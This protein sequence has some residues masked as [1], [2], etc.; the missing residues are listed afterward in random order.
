MRRL[1]ERRR[2]IITGVR[3]R[4]K[5]ENEEGET[6]GTLCYILHQVRAKILLLRRL[7]GVKRKDRN[8]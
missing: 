1:M 2:K 7:S 6:V 8:K 5:A 3:R 4:K